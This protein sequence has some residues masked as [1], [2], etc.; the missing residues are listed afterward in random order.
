VIVT[1][2]KKKQGSSLSGLSMPLSV[3]L[4]SS[5]SSLPFPFLSENSQLMHGLRFLPWK[6]NKNKNTT[7][8]PISA[9]HFK[10]DVERGSQSYIS[11]R[12]ENFYSI[13]PS[14]LLPHEIGHSFFLTTD[15][16][17]IKQDSAS[18]V[19]RVG[20]DA[21]ERVRDWQKSRTSLLGEA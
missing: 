14:I 19:P 6:K 13:W 21:Q 11:K 9:F 2:T 18:Q 3:T 7:T 12:E 4:L 17:G 8:Y 10:E 1:D 20:E 16:Q 15:T 5:P